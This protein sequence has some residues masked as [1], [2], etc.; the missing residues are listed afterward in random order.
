M[1]PYP[2]HIPSISHVSRGFA[3]CCDA[4]GMVQ[5]RWP[6]LVWASPPKLEMPRAARHGCQSWSIHTRWLHL[7]GGLEHCLVMFSFPYIENSHPNLL[8]CFRG[9]QTTNQMSYVF[10][11]HLI[12]HVRWILM[13][14]GIPTYSNW[15]LELFH[16]SNTWKSFR[17]NIHWITLMPFA[18]ISLLRSKHDEPAAYDR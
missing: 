16:C 3:G 13:N 8:I 1:Y 4:Q 7:V 5:Q 15:L 10:W 12:Q 17:C 6:T 18:Y 9:V 14:Y 11:V 2:I